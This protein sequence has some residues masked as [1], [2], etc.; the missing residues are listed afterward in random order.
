MVFVLTKRKDRPY[1][2]LI[3]YPHEAA[4]E[5]PKTERGVQ[6]K[7]LPLGGAVPTKNSV[8]DERIALAE[9]GC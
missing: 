8:L 3:D 1:G 6:A 4:V 5:R 7:E 9:S 2:F